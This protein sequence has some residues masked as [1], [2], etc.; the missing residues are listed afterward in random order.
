[1]VV[2][3]VRRR[4]CPPPSCVVLFC[5]PF[6]SRHAC[7]SRVLVLLVVV[8]VFLVSSSP[9]PRHL[10]FLLLVLLCHPLPHPPAAIWH[11]GCC[12][13]VFLCLG[14]RQAAQVV[15]SF[16]FSSRPLLFFF[17]VCG[18]DR[19]QRLIVLFLPFC[20]RLIVLLFSLLAARFFLL[21]A[22]GRGRRPLH[23]MIVVCFF[24]SC[25]GHERPHQ[26]IVVVVCVCFFCVCLRPRAQVDCCFFPAGGEIVVFVCS[27]CTQLT[28]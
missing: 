1:V 27:T 4:A 15:F 7:P 21:A 12:S 25:C 6:P 17:L 11:T 28:G 2:V 3:V 26:L 18:R 24:S 5:R 19:P 14:P 8:V 20:H 10:V 16:V 13:F 22:V 9:R 23:R